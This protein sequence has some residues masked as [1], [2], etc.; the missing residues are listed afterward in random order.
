MWLENS[1]LPW[2][3]VHLYFILLLLSIQPTWAEWPS[4][5]TVVPVAFSTMYLN[6]SMTLAQS[7]LGVSPT[8]FLLCG[9]LAC[10]SAANVVLL[11]PHT[12][13][14]TTPLIDL[15]A[16]ALFRFASGLHHW[17]SRLS[18]RYMSLCSLFIRLLLFYCFFSFTLLGVNV[19]RT[20]HHSGMYSLRGLTVALFFLNLRQ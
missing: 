18:Q 3:L 9:N 12:F 1:L 16:D 19:V 8:L 4:S 17:I 2:R 7:H 15:A 20:F 6:G 14:T 5:S 13:P 11:L 10:F